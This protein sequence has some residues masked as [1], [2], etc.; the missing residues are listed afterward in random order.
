MSL[1]LSNSEKKYC[2]V[3]IFIFQCIFSVMI[4]CF[5]ACDISNVFKT[6]N[7]CN[8]INEKVHLFN[9]SECTLKDTYI[10]WSEVRKRLIS[11]YQWTIPDIYDA[12]PVKV[13]RCLSFI[14]PCTSN[15]Y[16]CTPTKKDYAHM[17]IKLFKDGKRVGWVY[18]WI[19]EDRRC[20]CQRHKN[21]S[22]EHP[23]E[24]P[25]LNDALT[26]LDIW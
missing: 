16:Y 11:Q 22:N 20:K 4:G 13:K 12:E 1:P 19:N 21:E 8:L 9:E 17:F 10:H 25:L 7:T 23:W 6:K 5:I 26:N 18:I 3:G 2:I 14:S 15:N 24:M